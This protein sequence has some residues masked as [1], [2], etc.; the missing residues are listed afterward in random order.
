MILI[1]DLDDTL[2]DE[3][4]YVESGFRAVAAFGETRFGWDAEASFAFMQGAL[5]RY[6]RGTIFNRWLD[7]H[8][9]ETGALVR[10]CVRVYRH[11]RPQ[12]S[13][14]DDAHAVLDLYADEPLYLVTDGHKIAQ[15]RKVEALGIASRFRKVYITHRFGIAK[16]KPS[17]YCFERIRLREGC[18]W[19]EM[20]Y[21]ADNPAK[22][23][24]NL[25][26]L[27]VHTVRVLTGEHR[28]RL[29]EP[30]ADAEHRI[31]SLRELPPLLE[32][33]T[34]RSGAL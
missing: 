9:R 30:G 1:F 12:I 31:S 3:R 20:V 2:Y 32:H 8:G 5:G 33:L 15:Q 17:T 23:F 21:V 28:A 11:H 18:Q 16:A 26:P 4:Q 6:G 24:I 14:G 27:G 10:E 25:R 19:S 13:L 29:A 7:L 34:F 22:D